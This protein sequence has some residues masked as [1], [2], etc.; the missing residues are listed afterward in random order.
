MVM[1]AR[2]GTRIQGRLKAREP[3]NC[4][5]P[6]HQPAVSITITGSGRLGGRCMLP[7]FFKVLYK[8]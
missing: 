6:A 5:W 4:A 8:G 2:L 1:G 3:S 7:F